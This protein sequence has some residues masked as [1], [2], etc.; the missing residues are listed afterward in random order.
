LWILD[1]P[2]GEGLTAD[3]SDAGETHLALHFKVSLD[4]EYIEVRATQNGTTHAL[5]PRAHNELLLVLARQRAEDAEQR[6]DEPESAHG[7]VYAEDLE[8]M[9]RFRPARVRMDIFRAR[10]Q[11]A[12]AGIE[13]SA[14]LVERRASP[15]MLRLGV[16]DL[17]F[18]RV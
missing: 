8:R 9:L 10:K 2:G 16:A 6:A 11:L 4:E 5:E 17:S 13:D 15:R 14:M 1:L 18:G 12:E 7:W 3:L